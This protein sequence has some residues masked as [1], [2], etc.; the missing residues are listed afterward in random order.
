ME[1]FHNIASLHQKGMA[2][3][4]KVFG[5]QAW[6]VEFKSLAC[7]IH[8]GTTACAYNSSFVGQRRE[9]TSQPVYPN[10]ELLV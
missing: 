5:V 10:S 1:V 2:L 6:G 8:P 7:M 9:L 3:C 4:G